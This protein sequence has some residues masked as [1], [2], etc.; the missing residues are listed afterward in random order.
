M[1]Q[2][3]PDNSVVVWCLTSSVV[4][5]NTTSPGQSFSRLPW[6]TR[7]LPPQGLKSG[8]EDLFLGTWGVS[9][10]NVSCPLRGV[11]EEMA[12]SASRLWNGKAV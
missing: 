5:C 1:S 7:S 3:L 12:G 8:P 6:H 9:C 4:Y 10:P 2:P 11:V